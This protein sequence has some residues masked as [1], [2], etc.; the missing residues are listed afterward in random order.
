M[1]S[2]I[3]KRLVFHIG[4]YDVSMPPD[5]MH[6]RFVRELRRFERTW[7]AKACAS[8]P[9][10]SDDQSAWQVITTGPNWRVETDY[11]FVRW[12]DIID[13]GTGR[14]MWRRLALGVLAFF[15]FVAA[16]AL[17]GYLRTNWRY[18]LFFLYPFVVLVA[19]IAIAWFLGDLAAQASRSVL[20]GAAASVAAL[21][22][23]LQGP[24][25]WMYLPEL[26]DD[27]IFAREYILHSDT[28]LE[29]IGRAH[30]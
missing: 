10:L 8:E 21:I 1:S 24:F 7:S 13:S 16:G 25:R 22:A 5:V 29:Q 11:R 28:L 15:D 2:V 17:W 14:S 20:V 23:L 19:L 6:R 12:D 9:K 18:A 26:I 3:A 4:G 27:W 30:V